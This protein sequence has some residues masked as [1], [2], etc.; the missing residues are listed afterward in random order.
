MYNTK[1]VSKKMFWKDSYREMSHCLK[2]YQTV[3]I[4]HI[5]IFI[6]TKHYL[7]TAP[8]SNGDFWWKD[9]P[10]NPVT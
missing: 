1:K 7:L 4:F 10:L 5:S 9:N 2:I 3:L 8:N 6:I